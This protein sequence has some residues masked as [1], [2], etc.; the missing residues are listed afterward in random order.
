MEIVTPVEILTMKRMRNSIL[1]SLMVGLILPDAIFAQLNFNGS[2]GNFY[3]RSA[4]TLSPG[5]LTIRGHSRFFGKSATFPGQSSTTVKDV[6][7][8]INVNYGINNHLEFSATTLLYQDTN[9]EGSEI[10]A[11]GDLFVALKIGS[12]AAQ[13]SPMAYGVVVGARFP[14]GFIHNVPFEPYATNKVGFGFT[15]LLTYAGDAYYPD[16]AINVNLNVGYWFHNDVGAELIKGG[17]PATEP[18]VMSQ[19]IFYGVGVTIP[20]NNLEFSAEIYGNGFTQKPPPAAYSRENYLFF[21]PGIFYHATDWMT[22]NFGFDVR[23]LDSN[24]ETLYLPA[25]GGVSQ[26]FPGSQ[27]NY[28]SWR[29]NFGAN[30]TLLASEGYRVKD[31]ELLMQKA[32]SRRDLFEQIL[33]DKKETEAAEEEL[34]RIR[35]ERKKAEQELERLRR[36]LERQEKKSES[37]ESESKEKKKKPPKNE[38]F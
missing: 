27:P 13:G 38:P 9:F 1:M 6:S 29:L 26:L 37:K 14:T 31:R 15:G 21:S 7:S 36:I 8:R 28:P 10:N 35:E 32:K 23:L 19:E 18:T 16:D 5:Y 20:K 25:R 2:K 11:P 17:G 12:L 33:K 24:D 22:L 4:W 34:E 30:F 3:V